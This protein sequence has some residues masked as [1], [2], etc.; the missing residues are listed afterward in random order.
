[1]VTHPK[2]LRTG[3]PIW[4]AP[5]ERRLRH[6]PLTVDM[7]TDVL[8]IGAGITGAMIAEALAAAGR[9]V[10]V[11]DK[12]GP[13]KGSTAASTALVQ[14]AIDT[15][16]TQLAR[17]IGKQPAVRAWRRSRLAVDA[18]ATRL[19]EL[20]ATDVVSR[21]TLFLEGNRL[22]PKGLQREEAARRAAG[23][24]SLFLD[25][26]AV[27]SRF[28]ISGR[29]AL[30]DHGDFVLNPR[31]IT[32][33]FLRAAAIRKARIFSPVEIVDLEIMR[34][35]VTAVARHGPRI[36]ARYIVFATGYE[37]PK[38]LPQT[39]HKVI[40]TWAI[41][42]APQ[43]RKLWPEQCMIWEASEPYL[44]LRTTTDGRVI[45]GGE[46]EDFSDEKKRDLLL[47]VKARVLSRKLKRLLPDVDSGFQFCWAGSFGQTRTG[48]PKIGPLPGK[49]R[50]W[51]A[52]GYGGNGITHAQVASDIVVGALTG[53]PDIDADL[54]DFR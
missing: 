28:G 40:S 27:Q 31:T 15:P 5:R 6:G 35:G 44:Y 11:V 48:L 43:R 53:H 18:L 12:R 54:Y 29:A 21:S 30:L 50:C 20:K 9:E 8:V 49:S 17:K 3:Q 2:D 52:L 16:L 33:A 41:A 14:Y 26:A 37:V 45:C 23:L 13:A 46:D 32:L 39:G 10:V 19:K 47:S 22:D 4:N 42:T 36:A 7:K 38:G 1:M 51:V 25:R 34:T 24:A